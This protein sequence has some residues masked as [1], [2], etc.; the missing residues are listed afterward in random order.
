MNES[1]G[2]VLMLIN[3]KERTVLR[4]HIWYGINSSLGFIEAVHQLLWSMLHH[5]RLL[6][7]ERNSIFKPKS[8]YC[9][10]S[11]RARNIQ[12]VFCKKGIKVLTIMCDI[13]SLQFCCFGGAMVEPLPR[14]FISYLQIHIN[15]SFVFT[16]ECVET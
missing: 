1:M 11:Q 9:L 2:Y 3:L 7:H 15:K 16:N 5:R 4:N 12:K 8:T 14:R 6:A 10:W 13:L